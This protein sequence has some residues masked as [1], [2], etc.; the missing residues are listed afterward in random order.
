MPK[1]IAEAAIGR[2]NEDSD[3]QLRPELHADVLPPEAGAL[4][5]VLQRNEL[6]QIVQRFR[7]ADL[8]ALRAQARYKRIGRL[9]L[10]STSIATVIGAL[11]VLPIEALLKGFPAGLASVAQVSA[12]MIAFLASRLLAVSAPFDVWM[13]RRAEAEIARIDLFDTIARAEEPVQQDELPLLPLK[14]EYFRRYQLDVQRRYYHGRGAQHKAAAW[15]NNRWLSASM[16]FTIAALGLGAIL[17]LHTAAAWGIQLPEWLMT[18]SGNLVGSQGNRLVLGLGTI[19]SGLYGLGTARSLMDLDERNASRFLT[20]ADNLDFLTSTGLRRARDAA[21]AA[22]L[23]AVLGFV[24]RV[25]EQIS[26]EHREWVLLQSVNVITGKS[27]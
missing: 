9:A 26:S 7:S 12:L 11:F 10:Y 5:R 21:E 22:D 13:K 25:Q 6:K 19:A 15:R 24:G 1:T 16:L 2:D 8:A 17:A 27:P 18:W 3:W 14:L 23:K 4:K 20:T